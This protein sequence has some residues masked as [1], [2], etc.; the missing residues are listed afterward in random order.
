MNASTKHTAAAQTILERISI[1]RETPTTHTA[2]QSAMPRSRRLLRDGIDTG[3]RRGD[4][5]GNDRVPFGE[6]QDIF[7]ADGDL[8]QPGNC[9]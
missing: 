8:C 3:I 6:P 2:T 9:E 7:L 4:Q 1:E 5:P